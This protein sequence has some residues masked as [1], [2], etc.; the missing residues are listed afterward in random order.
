MRFR[1][2]SGK[3]RFCRYFTIVAR[4]KN[5]IHSLKPYLKPGFKLCAT[6]LN[7]AKCLKK[8]TVRLRLF[9]STYLKP[10]RYCS[11]CGGRKNSTR[12]SSKVQSFY[13]IFWGVSGSFY[14]DKKT[15]FVCSLLQVKI[16]I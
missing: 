2:G 5:A 12:T 1:C 7:V 11:R 14:I 10:V 3:I 8:S 4:F 6:F 9:F 16:P 13:Y 15:R